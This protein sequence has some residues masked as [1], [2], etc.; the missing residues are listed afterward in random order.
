M[1]SRIIL[2]A[3]LVLCA[4]AP[5]KT[6]LDKYQLNC[7]AASVSL[8][9]DSMELPYTAY[10]NT[11]GQ[12][13]SVVTCN[14]DGSFRYIETYA[15]NSRHELEELMDVNA[16]NETET[17]YEFEMD[18]RFVRECRIYGMNNQEI[19]R[20]V[21][22]NDGRHIVKSDYYGEGVLEYTTTKV[23]SGSRYTE[24]SRTPDG[25]LLGRADV[26]FF[27]DES[28]PCRI[29]GYEIDV[30]VEYN[31]AGLPV[32]SR[33]TVLDSRGQLQW[34]HDLEV[35]PVRLYTYEYDKRGNWISRAERVH[36]DSAAVAVLRRVIVY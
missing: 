17:R 25:E 15:Y 13:D 26:E 2:A 5:V 4:C 28:K 9:S 23:F 22:D 18:G 1:K 24:E 31:E 11:R 3:A 34:I 16:D 19:H 33:N 29:S 21:H 10:F 27:R 14:Y 35:N 36:P 7:K 30:E 8:Q 20:W 6:D 32:M 12:L